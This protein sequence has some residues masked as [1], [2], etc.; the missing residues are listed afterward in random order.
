MIEPR[1]ACAATSISPVI[2][3]VVEP[4]VTMS[5]IDW[6]LVPCIAAQRGRALRCV[7]SP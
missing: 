7:M 3:T 2:S 5:T 6:S 4:A 1:S